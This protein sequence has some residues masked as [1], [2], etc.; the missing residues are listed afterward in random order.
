MINIIYI[1]NMKTN[2]IRIL[3]IFIFLMGH[4]IYAQENTVSG[5]VVDNNGLAMPGVTVTIKGTKSGTQTDF[6]GKFS[7]KAN[8]NQILV[9]SF[10]GMKTQEIAA[11]TKVINLTMYENAQ[12]LREVVVTALGIKRERK[13]LGYAT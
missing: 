1:T 4:I 6:D 9:F 8:E 3:T 12:E 11:T 7:L 13:A 10:I 2:F 5:T